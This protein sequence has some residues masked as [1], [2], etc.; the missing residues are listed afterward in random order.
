MVSCLDTE[1]EIYKELFSQLEN[2]SIDKLKFYLSYLLP[3]Y[4]E[5]LVLSSD[6]WFSW[7]EKAQYAFTYMINL[8]GADAAAMIFG[9]QM[10]IK[11]ASKL[12]DDSVYLDGPIFSLFPQNNQE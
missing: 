2:S 4:T 9:I 6:L 3:L 5:N 12:K 8:C 1:Y 7:N 11:N 10:Q